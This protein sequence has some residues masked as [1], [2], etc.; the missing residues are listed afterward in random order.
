[1]RLKEKG[2]EVMKMVK[3]RRDQDMPELL[4]DHWQILIGTECLELRVKLNGKNYSKK[5]S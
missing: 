4:W 2:K 5:I 1:M 3:R